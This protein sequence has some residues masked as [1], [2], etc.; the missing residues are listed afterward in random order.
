MS[1]DC[2]L[3]MPAKK[4]RR[5]N[6]NR[7]IINL[8]KRSTNEFDYIF[9]WIDLEEGMKVTGDMTFYGMFEEVPNDIPD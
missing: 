9:N 8:K 7:D 3:L 5:L 4:D 2:S 6:S 1:H